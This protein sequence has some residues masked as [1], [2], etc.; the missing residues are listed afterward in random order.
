MIFGNCFDNWFLETLRLDDQIKTDKIA[1]WVPL[2][3]TSNSVT[4]TI[5]APLYKIRDFTGINFVIKLKL[6]ISWS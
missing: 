6:K 5:S 4:V 1:S 3:D 2:N